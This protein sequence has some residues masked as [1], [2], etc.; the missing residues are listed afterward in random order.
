MIHLSV[1]LYTSFQGY[2]AV[3]PL[4]N[5]PLTCRVQ[6]QAVCGNA[7]ICEEWQD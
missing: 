1:N 4:I 7:T 5:V 3:T 6:P 2:H